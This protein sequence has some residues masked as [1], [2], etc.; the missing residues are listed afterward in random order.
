[1]EDGISRLLYHC[2]KMCYEK[3]GHYRRQACIVD[4]GKA[5]SLQEYIF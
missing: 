3:G 1:M 2:Y 5:V 4:I